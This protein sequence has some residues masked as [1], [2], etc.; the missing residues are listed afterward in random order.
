MT[1]FHELLEYLINPIAFLKV[2]LITMLERFCFT[3][4]FFDQFEAPNCFLGQS[5]CFV[6][7]EMAS[8]CFENLNE[9]DEFV[10]IR[11]PIYNISME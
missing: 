4:R 6:N 3:S 11:I 7:D 10:T 1:E 2:P 5:T 9:N 8:H